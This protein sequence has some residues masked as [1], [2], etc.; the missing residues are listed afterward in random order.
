M[1]TI[2]KS[3]WF[4][5]FWFLTLEFFLQ[6]GMSFF[7]ILLFTSNYKSS[8]IGIDPPPLPPFTHTFKGNNK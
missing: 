8:N 1:K 2:H 7:F 3:I 6:R 5:Q 4:L